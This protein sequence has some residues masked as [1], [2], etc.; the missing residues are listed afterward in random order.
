[1]FVFGM[2]SEMQCVV[3]CIASDMYVC[4]EYCQWYVMFVFGIA[5][6]M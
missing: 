4:L 1:M 2:A 6:D 3:F 5:S